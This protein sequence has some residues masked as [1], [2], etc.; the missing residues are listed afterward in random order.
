MA[1][2]AAGE[3]IEIIITIMDPTMG[4]LS[5]Y[6]KSLRSGKIPTNLQICFFVCNLFECSKCCNYTIVGGF[7]ITSKEV[8]FLVIGTL[9]VVI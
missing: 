1:D 3:D 5:K 6:Y 4:T 8:T 2:L 9:P 7:I